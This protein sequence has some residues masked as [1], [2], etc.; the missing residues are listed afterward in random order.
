MSRMIYR[1]LGVVLSF[2]LLLV[3]GCGNILG[4]GTQEGTR[5][6]HLNPIAES[7]V[8]EGIFKTKE[9][10]IAIAIAVDNFPEY[11]QRSQIVTRTSDNRLQ[12][13]GFDQWAEP[14]ARGFTEA[15][16]VNLSV[17]LSTDRIYIFPWRKNRP[18]DYEILLDVSRFDGELGSEVVLI[19]R[20][21]IFDHS[22]KEELLTKAA[23]LIEPV[24]SKDYEAQVAAM[25][26]VVGNLAL[27][28]AKSIDTVRREGSG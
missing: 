11:L 22:G 13:A 14:L 21:S 15:L 18:I 26:R 27:E 4:K 2:S 1:F 23:K 3:G 10:R 19:A 17:H 5:F 24:E 20:W 12:F 25:S 9:Q 28:I 7:S 6:Y 16:V 8:A